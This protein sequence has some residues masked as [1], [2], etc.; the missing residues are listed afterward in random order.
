M[1][2]DRQMFRTGQVCA[3]LTK[4]RELTALKVMKRNIFMAGPT[5]QALHDSSKSPIY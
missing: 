1:L 3:K 5:A 4:K 2:A